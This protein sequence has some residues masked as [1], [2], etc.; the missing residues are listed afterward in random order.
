T[1]A[2]GQ[3]SV[4]VHVLQGERPMA[5]DN[6]TLG[7][8]HLDGIPP[9][10]RGVPQ[11]EL[12]YDID[13][14]GI[15][16][17]AA[18]DRATGKENK[19][20]IT[21]SSGLSKDDVERAVKEAQ[22]H[23]AEDKQRREEIE[24]R[25]RADNLAYA[26]EKSLKDL[27][28]KIPA[29][30]KSELEAKV[31]AVRDALAGSDIEAVKSAS[32]TLMQAS[33]RMAEEAYK[34]A[35]GAPGEAGGAAGPEAGSQPG[36]PPL[37]DLGDYWFCWHGFKGY[38]GVS[39]HLRKATFPGRPRFTHPEFDHET[40][41]VTARLG[42]LLLASVYVPNGAKDL[43]AKIRFLEGL[44][45]FAAAAQAEGVRLLLCGDLNVARE[46]RD[47]HP[48]LRQQDQTGT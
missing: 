35:G 4:E 44:E 39:L 36:A 18:K 29:A 19:I 24:I 34:A 42:D 33:H 10:P 7:R 2:D 26:T 32:E 38:S 48:K 40:R 11:I 37:C 15:V 14:N 47:V 3:T 23:E 13:A 46:E 9:A 41:I 27:G 21:A 5:R 28:D 43:P 17:V 22:S 25:N 12:T 6:K 1:A 20:T 30:T 8:F 45:K 31:K 16:H